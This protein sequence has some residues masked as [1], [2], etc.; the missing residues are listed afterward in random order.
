VSERERLRVHDGMLHNNSDGS[1]RPARFYHSPEESCPSHQEHVDPEKFTTWQDGDGI[2]CIR[3]GHDC[4]GGKDTAVSVGASA[5][6][7]RSYDT[8]D[9]GN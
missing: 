5:A 8:V 9:W 3:R 7:S 4:G 6:Y 1:T 2:L